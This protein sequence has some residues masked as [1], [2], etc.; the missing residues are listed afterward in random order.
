M[1]IAFLQHWFSQM[2]CQL[3]CVTKSP[4]LSLQGRYYYFSTAIL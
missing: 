3:Q 2:A 4:S 1:I